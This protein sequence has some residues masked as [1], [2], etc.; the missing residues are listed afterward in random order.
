MGRD[1][2]GT[3]APSCLSAA[4][5][6]LV[7]LPPL[8]VALWIDAICWAHNGAVVTVI[9]DS[10]AFKA[11]LTE[12]A[13][14]LAVNGM[15]YSGDLLKDAIREAVT[16]AKPIE[17]IIKNSDRY[18]VVKLDYHTGLRYPHLERDPAK[19]GGTTSLEAIFAPKN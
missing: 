14:L 17:L 2:E 18:Q 4:V 1:E 12:G 9:W 11:G 5:S 6:R 8:V 16:D 10:P 15:S 13:Q 7:L 19:H 3:E